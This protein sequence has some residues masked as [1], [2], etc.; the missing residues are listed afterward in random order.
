MHVNTGYGNSV[1]ESN[2][3]FLGMEGNLIKQVWYM[4][5]KFYVLEELERSLIE[6]VGFL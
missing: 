1:L 4:N 6:I 3:I 2:R 5:S